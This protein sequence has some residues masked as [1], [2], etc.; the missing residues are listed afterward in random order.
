MKRQGAKR[1]PN[2]KPKAKK[3]EKREIEKNYP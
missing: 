1:N 2:K 3:E